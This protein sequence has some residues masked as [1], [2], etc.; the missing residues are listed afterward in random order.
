MKRL[1]LRIENLYAD[2]R[3]TAAMRSVEEASAVI[4]SPI[5]TSMSTPLPLAETKLLI[6]RLNPPS[7]ALDHIPDETNDPEVDD[8]LKFTADHIAQVLQKLPKGS[9]NGF[10]SW[11]YAII[12]QLYAP[13]K[14]LPS[15]AAESSRHLTIIAKL[16]TL[17]VSGV[18]SNEHW[19]TSRAVLLPKPDNGWRPLGIG[20]SWYRFLNRTILL[21]VGADT[22]NQLLPCQLGCGIQGGSEIA[23]RL[24]QTILDAN[25]SFV[26]IK[27]DFKNAFNLT[28]RGKIYEGL[29]RYCPKLLKWFR[30]A[31]GDPSDLLDNKGNW[32]GSSQTGCRQGDPLASLLFC[33][34]I[35]PALLGIKD[36]IQEENDNYLTHNPENNITPGNAY[37]YMDDFNIGVSWE[38]SN[39][40]ILRLIQICADNGLTLNL[41]K[42]HT[43]G[44]ATVNI[45]DPIFTPVVDGEVVMGSPTGTLQYRQDQCVK[46]T[47]SMITPLS[48]LSR[49]SLSPII[50]FNLI[51]QCL[52]PRACYLSRVQ[53]PPASDAALLLFD[54]AIDQAIAR[55]AQHSIHPASLASIA[56]I[57]SLPPR[58]SGLGI[59]RFSWIDGQFG[60]LRSRTLTADFI[61]S[62]PAFLHLRPGTFAWSHINIGI[63][64]S[65]LHNFV[66]HNPLAQILPAESDDQILPVE[67]RSLSSIVEAQ[68][69]HAWQ[70]L[71]LHLCSHAPAS[72]AWF[73][74]SRFDGSG[75]WLTPP[76]G[77]FQSSSLVLHPDEYTLALRSR[78]LLSPFQDHPTVPSHCP[79]GALISPTEPFHFTDCHAGKCFLTMR[80]T[81]V[82]DILVKFLQRRFPAI[83]ITKSPV[84]LAPPNTADRWYGD[85]QIQLPSAHKIL[86]ITVSDPA[87][88]T[89]RRLTPES[90]VTHAD[91]TN[92]CR[93]T[94][95]TNHYA[96][97]PSDIVQRGLFVPFAV[98]AT[99][100]LGPAALSFLQ[101]LMPPDRR[102]LTPIS[103]LITQ[104]GTVI[105]KSNA[106]ATAYLMRGA[107]MW[108]Q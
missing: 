64:N 29:R 62:Q 65:P 105:A 25:P 46:L 9:S 40:V 1:R 66:P 77:Y 12:R 16:F 102:G 27:T 80:H 94:Q 37:G 51:K 34:A 14:E 23:A 71:Y 47:N 72:A 56:T 90:S 83:I 21:V 43:L 7:S 2:G 35:Q 97:S 85:L 73:L 91:A 70:T 26:I 44:P 11:T 60:C 74:S 52:T 5:T 22:G 78:L 67:Q 87:A 6:A 68:Y 108:T 13:P 17:L 8:P 28:P 81:S 15:L 18:L 3:L 41:S 24:A 107:C 82:Q 93:E 98:E 42:C 36:V 106:Q 55:I 4:D 104:I 30:W 89:Y 96:L 48:T 76:I 31:Y 59:H 45:V 69:A 33:V 38:I 10:S 63:D 86:D 88:P 32:V 58:L 49:L 103:T 99:G 19:T 57:R 95:K 100:R 20:E 61:N 54:A 84:L 75:K 101:T 53:D 79:C 50:I 92:R 39:P